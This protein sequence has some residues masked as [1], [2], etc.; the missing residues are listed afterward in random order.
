MKYFI[1]SFIVRARIICVDYAFER[2]TG[3]PIVFP[4]DDEFILKYAKLILNV[5]QVERQFLGIGL[6][7][8]TQKA[9]APYERVS[10]FFIIN[11]L[12]LF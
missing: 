10:S 7:R 5:G 12:N 4:F 11:Y 2:H 1:H 9:V 8:V 3:A 6:S